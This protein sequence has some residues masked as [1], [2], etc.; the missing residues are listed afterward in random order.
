M[1]LSWCETLRLEDDIRLAQVREFLIE[2]LAGTP[3][4]VACRRARIGRQDEKLS[5]GHFQLFQV[6]DR[7]FESIRVV[8][9]QA[10]DN[11]RVRTDSRIHDAPETL[12]VIINGVKSFIDLFKIL[13]RKGFDA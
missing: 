7:L 1:Q 13:R 4:L 12:R 2:H 3:Y 10:E 9:G 5:D 6:L 8:I 11:Q